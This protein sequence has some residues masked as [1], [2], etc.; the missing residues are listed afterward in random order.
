MEEQEQV[1]E[2]AAVETPATTNEDTPSVPTEETFTQDR[3]NEIVQERLARA[4]Q[5]V[6]ERYGVNNLE[7]LD[8]IVKNTQNWHDEFDRVTIANK[9]LT[10]NNLFLKNNID[11]A[12][13]DDINI[14]FK[15]AELEFE[16]DVFSDVLAKHPEWLSKPKI[17][18]STLGKRVEERHEPT[19]DEKMK[20]IFGV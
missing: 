15:G 1:V 10:K 9:E 8:E 16:E 6:L 12:K 2:Q 3:V 14:Y 17:V 4:S 19:D 18:I 20:T 11:P 7:E 5:K 13:Y